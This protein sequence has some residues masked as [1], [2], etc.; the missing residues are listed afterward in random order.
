MS[1]ETTTVGYPAHAL[2]RYSR[3]TTGNGLLLTK[4]RAACG[5]TGEEVG[6][7]PFRKAGSARWRELCTTC[8][9]ARHTTPHPLAALVAPEEV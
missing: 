7:N 3:Q 4:W 6:L 9:P 2:A 5:A 1:A 8:F